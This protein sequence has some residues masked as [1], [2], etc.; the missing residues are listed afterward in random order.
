MLEYEPVSLERG[1]SKSTGTFQ[2][3]VGVTKTPSE[4]QGPLNWVEGYLACSKIGLLTLYLIDSLHGVHGSI[5][6]LFN[7]FQS[8]EYLFQTAS[9]RDN[10]CR[11]V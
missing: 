6:W 5:V 1:M 8:I 11:I 9:S 7:V 3:T 2:T 4:T 10:Q